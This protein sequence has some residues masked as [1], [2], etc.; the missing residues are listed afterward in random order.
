[1]ARA[2]YEGIRMRADRLLSILLLLQSRGKMTA[3]ELSERLEVSE[4]TIYRD[5][6]ALSIAGVPVYGEPGPE[7]GY[8]LV[9]RYRTDLTGLTEKEL[10]ALFMLS[11]PAPLDEL[12]M[13]EELR[14]A[15]LK[16]SAALPDA[17]RQEQERIGQRFHLDSTWWRQAE[18]PVP[19]LQTIHQ[20]VLQNRKLHV[21]YHPFFTTVLERLVAPFG[22]VAKAGIWYLVSERKGAMHVR[23]VSSYTDVSMAEESFERPTDF[24][25]AAFWEAWSSR[26]ERLLSVFTTTVRVAEEFIPEL[27]R[28]FG[29]S[30][31]TKLEETKQPDSEGWIQL[32]LQFDS[33]ETAR[34]RLLGLGRSV[35]VIEPEAL[36]RSVLDYA[37][38][39]VSL[40]ENG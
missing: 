20:A 10:R 15:L 25:L 3:L 18:E 23:R 11:V 8:A 5:M 32:Q 21:K 34:S 36:R 38:Q 22:L 35:K 24:D 30:I 7:G 13:S 2:G 28:H 16:L 12:G 19:H 29:Q 1:M 17:H 31:H 40:Y 37:E 6:E 39:I 33:F 14:A 4:R 26:Y 9:E 27:P